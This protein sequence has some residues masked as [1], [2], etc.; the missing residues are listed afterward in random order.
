MLA[1]AKGTAPDS[2]FYWSSTSSGETVCAGESRGSF[3]SASPTLPAVGYR[4]RSCGCM[5]TCLYVCTCVCICEP[6]LISAAVDT[7]SHMCDGWC[8]SRCEWIYVWMYMWLYSGGIVVC[9]YDTASAHTHISLSHS[10]FEEDMG[11]LLL[12]FS[13]WNRGQENTPSD[14]IDRNFKYILWSDDSRSGY[15]LEAAGWITEDFFDFVA[16]REY[17]SLDCT[18]KREKLD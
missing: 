18:Q 1:E 2:R 12:A 10:N 6:Q 16:V 14:W 3:S 17:A 13:W 5:S 7:I 11:T 8:E 4:V 9:I 15:G